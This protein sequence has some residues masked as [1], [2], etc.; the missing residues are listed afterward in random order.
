MSFNLPYFYCLK[1]HNHV[2][3]HC[4]ERLFVISR[5]LIDNVNVLSVVFITFYQDNDCIQFTA[6]RIA[7]LQ[8]CSC[9]VPVATSTAV[10]IFGINDKRC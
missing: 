2:E 3:Q 5:F 6:V 7:A 8:K 9:T 1:F 10:I 4:N